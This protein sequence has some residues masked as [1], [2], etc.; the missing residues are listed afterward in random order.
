MKKRAVFLSVAVC[1]VLVLA[2]A[3][4]ACNPE[5]GDKY[6]YSSDPIIGTYT[7]EYESPYSYGEVA[8]CYMTITSCK[9]EDPEYRY[10]THFRCNIL[11]AELYEV[12]GNIFEPDITY[13]IRYVEKEEII[14][15]NLEK[16][17]YTVA[18]SQSLTCEA[19]YYGTWDDGVFSTGNDILVFN[20]YDRP[21]AN[22]RPDPGKVIGTRTLVRTAMTELQF[23]N[24]CAERFGIG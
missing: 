21:Y 1:M 7:M 11:R 20:E 4:V 17:V 12:G 13:E 16:K 9:A 8:L 22:N 18:D 19:N 23:R 5:D 6:D 14:L 3:L 10:P 24:S 15:Y 2:F